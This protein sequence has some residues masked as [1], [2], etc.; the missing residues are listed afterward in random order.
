MVGAAGA[1]GGDEGSEETLVAEG[2]QPPPGVDV[3][4]QRQ[5]GGFV[6]DQGVVGELG[7]KLRRRQRRLLPQP[8]RL[9]RGRGGVP[10]FQE[11]PGQLGG[12]GIR[13]GG[14]RLDGSD[15]IL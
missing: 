7:K 12:G 6:K 10:A 13:V 14:Q 5:Q 4:E 15:E 9:L 2:A 11:F 1:G 3:G 8:E